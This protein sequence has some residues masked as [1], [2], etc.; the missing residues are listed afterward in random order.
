[1]KQLKCKDL[2]AGDIM[3]KAD[4]GSRINAIIKL[5]QKAFGERNAYVTHAGLMYDNVYIIESQR[6]GVVA[7]DLRGSDDYGYIVFRSKNQALASGAAQMAKILFDAHK[8]K[9]NLKYG[10]LNAALSLIKGDKNSAGDKEMEKV[11]EKIV[12]NGKHKFFCSQLVAFIYQFTARQNGLKAEDVINLHDSLVSPSRLA[13]LLLQN[14]E[15]FEQ[16]G[17]MMPKER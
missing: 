17:Y 8:G 11:I 9:K 6:E 1:M 15:M 7:S 5:G 12:G 13:E 4:D 10:L 14:N 16:V 2:K 3:L